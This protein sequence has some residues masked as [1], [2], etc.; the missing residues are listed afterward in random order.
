MALNV[1]QIQFGENKYLGTYNQGI[2][3]SKVDDLQL[4]NLASI[5]IFDDSPFSD[6]YFKIKYEL[7][8]IEGSAYAHYSEDDTFFPNCFPFFPEQDVPEEILNKYEIKKYYKPLRGFRNSTHFYD[9]IKCF[10]LTEGINYV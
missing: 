4:R 1:N 8:D 6:N 2:L 7:R 3:Y 10:A 5:E 9:N